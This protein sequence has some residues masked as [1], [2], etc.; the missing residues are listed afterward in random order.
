MK[1]IAGALGAVSV[2][3]STAGCIQ[4]VSEQDRDNP[5]DSWARGDAGDHDSSSGGCL[6]NGDCRASGQSCIG[7]I[8][9]A[10]TATNGTCDLGDTGDCVANNVCVTTTCKRITGQPCTMANQCASD[11]CDATGHCGVKPECTENSF[12][13]TFG[14]SCIGGICKD[15]SATYGSCDIGDNDDCVASHTCVDGTCKRNVGELCTNGGDCVTGVCNVTCQ[16]QWTRIDIPSVPQGKLYGVWGS[17]ANDVWAV[18]VKGDGTG[19]VLRWTG[20]AWSNIANP[21]PAELLGVWGRNDLDVWF[22]G[23]AYA[24]GAI[25][26]RWTGTGWSLV[27]NPV[28]HGE[29]SSVWGADG[30]DMWAV[31]T[32]DDS[33]AAVTLNWNGTEWSQVTNPVPSGA[34]QGVWGT[35]QSNVWAV[36]NGDPLILHW[37]G[38]TW[39]GCSQSLAAAL[40]GLWGTGE[41]NIWTAGVDALGSVQ[42]ML[43]GN[44]TDW[45]SGAGFAVGELY[46]VWGASES[47]VWAVGWDHYSATTLQWTGGWSTIPNPVSHGEL[48]GIWGSGD[49]DIWAVGF[50]LDSSTPV[51]L[52]WG[53]E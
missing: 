51:I 34:L 19:L 9:Q 17:G 52:H 41:T 16:P 18:G 53:L 39:S 21:A 37:N 49:N 4:F 10:K 13:T 12:C 48:R 3:A 25:T 50:D 36:G 20:S 40:F 44:G 43:F 29:L 2:L 5:H 15:R 45:N 26:M 8:C 33:G 46:G 23:G 42:L 14:Q 24:S 28:L 32:D 35:S 1:T 7:G 47:N 22:V 11:F 27:S 31:G 38:S 30:S 6:G